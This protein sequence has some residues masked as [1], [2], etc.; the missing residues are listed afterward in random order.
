MKNLIKKHIEV[1]KKIK[2][3]IEPFTKDCC[4]SCK[5]VC[6]K[7]VFCRES[8]ESA[9]LSKI[10]YNQNVEYHKKKGWFG[11]NGCRLRYGRPP[12]C[13]EFFCGRF[14]REGI[15]DFSSKEYSYIP[16]LINCFVLYGDNA[17]NNTHLICV[18]NLE[19]IS[20]KRFNEM[21]KSLNNISRQLDCKLSGIMEVQ[22]L[23]LSEHQ[24]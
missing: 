5:K 19:L 24:I 7:E 1:E 9:F 3:I 16:K 13:Y 18:D 11:E 17:Y 6:C 12:V 15:L 10:V 20:K 21:T 8:I 4:S 23:H 2:R 22:F 14:Y